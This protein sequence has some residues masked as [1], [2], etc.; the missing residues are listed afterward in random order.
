MIYDIIQCMDKLD[1]LLKQT[2]SDLRS[3]GIPV[4][5][6]IDP[7]V[8]IS[9][10]AKKR[11]GCCRISSDTGM[12][13]IEIS[14]FMLSDDNADML[15]ETMAHEVLHT[16]PG[17]FNHGAA[18]KRYAAAVNGAFGYDVSR[19]ADPFTDRIDI[20]PAK[21][22]VICKKCGRRFERQRECK[23]TKRPWLYRCSCG[24]KLEK[25]Y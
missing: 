22:V 10:R 8:S 1:I 19:T 25:L 16:C 12:Y 5:D 13:T 11:L 9:K 6:N 7:H 17:C 18:W 24:G 21:H 4:P 14:S 23:L 20:P 3:V 2:V 15:R